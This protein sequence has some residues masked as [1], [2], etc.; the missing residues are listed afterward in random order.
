MR[1]T[2]ADL[3]R[4]G[5]TALY[6]LDVSAALAVLAEEQAYCR[7]IVDNSLTFYIMSGRHPIVEQALR[8]QSVDPFLAYCVCITHF[9]L[10][11]ARAI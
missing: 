11:L 9:F 4:N 2:T 1:F 6:A 5:A 7:P 10:W 3:I 8:R